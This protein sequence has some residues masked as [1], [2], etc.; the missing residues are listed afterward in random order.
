MGRK[1]M[2]FAILE[3]LGNSDL[4]HALKFPDP[5]ERLG[6]LQDSIGMVLG[7]MRAE[8]RKKNICKRLKSSGLY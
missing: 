5:Y 7:R 8:T 4:E 3:L 2:C 6:A 1:E